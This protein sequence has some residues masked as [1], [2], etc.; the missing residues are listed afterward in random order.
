MYIAILA[1]LYSQQKTDLDNLIP[2]LGAIALGAHRVLP[3][4]Q[5]AYSAITSI[6]GGLDL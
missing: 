5:G 3:L 1:Y 6:N 2:V 4:L